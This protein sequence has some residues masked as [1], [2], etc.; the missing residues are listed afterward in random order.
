SS[1]KRIQ[2]LLVYVPVD[3]QC[4]GRATLPGKILGHLDDIRAKC[5]PPAVVLNYS[6]H[7]IS[8]TLIVLRFNQVSSSA[9][10]LYHRAG[11]GGNHRAPTSHHFKGRQPETF[12]ERRIN[13]SSRTPINGGQMS[14]LHVPQMNY[15]MMA[16]MVMKVPGDILG[17]PTPSPNQEQWPALA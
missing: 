9:H 12:I 13:Q 14:V 17:V 5:L 4:F 1:G 6:H 10:G 16:S 15:P 8:P 2:S 11:R 7:G 3:Y